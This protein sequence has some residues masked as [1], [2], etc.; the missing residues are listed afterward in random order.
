MRTVRQLKLEKR[1][2][3]IGHGM[4]LEPLNIFGIFSSYISF[5]PFILFSHV[6]VLELNVAAR[7]LSTA[8]PIQFLPIGLLSLRLQSLRCE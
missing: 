2:C 7:T 4:C 1:R 5:F 6:L 3:L 8:L